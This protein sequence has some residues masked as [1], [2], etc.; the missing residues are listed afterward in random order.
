[1]FPTNSE[2]LIGISDAFSAFVYGYP[3]SCPRAQCTP[4]KSAPTLR[5]TRRH[6]PRYTG[7]TCRHLP[8]A[9]PWVS[10][11]RLLTLYSY[12]HSFLIIVIKLFIFLYSF[13]SLKREEVL[14]ILRYATK[15]FFV[16]FRFFILIFLSSVQLLTETQ[17]SVGPEA[18]T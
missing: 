18:L 9:V 15:G 4:N 7:H 12:D 17:K 5:Y 1:M 3:S 10:E 6:G 2:R 13:C 8:S 11:D 14:F 16:N